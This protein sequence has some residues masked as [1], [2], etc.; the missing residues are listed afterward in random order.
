LDLNKARKKHAALRGSVI[1]DKADP[2]VRTPL[3]T[4]GHRYVA[5]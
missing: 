3:S 2:T 1:A 5:R 4:D